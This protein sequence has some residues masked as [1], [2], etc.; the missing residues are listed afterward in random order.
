MKNVLLVENDDMSIKVVLYFLKNDYKVDVAKDGIIALQMIKEK[1]YSA[2]LMDIE[3]GS[4]MNGLELVN[5]INEFPDYKNIPV[6][7]VTAY[8]LQGDREKFLAQGCTDYISKPFNKKEI[9][10]LLKNIL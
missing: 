2:I 6:V 3:L 10:M 4:P 9:I 8:D 7:A 1:K 5:R